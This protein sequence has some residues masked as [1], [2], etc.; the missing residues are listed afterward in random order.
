M[1]MSSAYRLHFFTV[2]VG[3]RISRNTCRLLGLLLSFF[4]SNAMLGST[5]DHLIPLDDRLSRM[6][7]KLK[8][9]RELWESKLFLSTGELARF[10]HVAGGVGEEYAV[11]VHSG[12]KSDEYWLTVTKS[13]ISLWEYVR[14][15]DQ[16]TKLQRIKIVRCDIPLPK[17]VAIAIN[18][19]FLAMLLRIRPDPERYV[20]VDST[21]E[22]FCVNYGGKLLQGQLPFDAKGNALELYEIAVGLA[23][24]CEVPSEGLPAHLREVESM[25]SKLVKRLNHE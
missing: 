5:H 22:M 2:A 16:S 17:S 13:P 18:N 12:T 11:S 8:T 7:G 4:L 23:I 10:A 14:A 25:A 21:T 1:S 3:L 9:Y 19:A 6:P 15:T 20:V 24:C